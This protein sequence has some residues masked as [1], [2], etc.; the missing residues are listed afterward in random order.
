MLLTI[1]RFSVVAIVMLFA[2]CDYSDA[3]QPPT[4]PI[5]GGPNLVAGVYDLQGVNGA[6]PGV[7]T[8]NQGLQLTVTGGTTSLD[9]LGTYFAS[10]TLDNGTPN[11]DS[12]IGGGVWT[13]ANGATT[14]NG[15]GPLAG[16]SGR[17]GVGILT[18][19]V[20]GAQL[21]YTKR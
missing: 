17:V 7:V 6:L 10:L 4:V 19:N 5:G 16:S 11:G 2:S 8:T 1:R 21:S 20:R 18:V 3:V 15:N 12:W 9:S 14:F 13:D